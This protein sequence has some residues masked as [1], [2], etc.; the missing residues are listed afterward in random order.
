MGPSDESNKRARDNAFTP[1]PHKNGKKQNG[2]ATPKGPGPSHREW[3][4]PVYPTAQEKRGL[5]SVVEQFTKLAMESDLPESARMDKDDEYSKGEKIVGELEKVKPMIV[6]EL[7]THLENHL[8]SKMGKNLERTEFVGTFYDHLLKRILSVVE[9]EDRQAFSDLATQMSKYASNALF[10]ELQDHKVTP[11]DK[12]TPHDINKKQEVMRYC[13]PFREMLIRITDSMLEQ[14]VAN[15]PSIA[16]KAGLIATMDTYYHRIHNTMADTSRK[17]ELTIDQLARLTSEVTDQDNSDSHR[18]LV[19]R[20]LADVIQTRETSAPQARAQREQ[21]AREYI[22]STI[23]FK[24]P[25]T[26][27]LPPS[28]TPGSGIAIVTTAFEKDKYKLERLI[29][30]ARSNGA[31]NISSKRWTPTDKPFSNLPD[32]ARLSSMLKMEMKNLFKS[33][34]LNLR[35][36]TDQK[37]RERAEATEHKFESAIN[38]HD[39]NPRKVLYGNVNSVQYEFLCPVSRGI[40][41]IYR[42]ANTYDGYDFSQEHPNPKLRQMLKSDPGLADKHGFRSK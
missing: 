39:Y 18:M 30:Q 1:S 16:R 4:K 23:G 36:S 38:D 12:D 26:I 7:E 15:M 2:Q 32:A 13:N 25:F 14:G 27:T 5:P 10:E 33:Q 24:G 21:E 8:I 6:K 17:L 35:S 41:M 11:H 22:L 20:G 3:V 42:G 28:K 34:I 40:M 9:Q 29:S 37:V 19:I 31:T